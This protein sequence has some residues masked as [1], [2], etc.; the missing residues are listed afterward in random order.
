VLLRTVYHL[1]LPIVS[2]L[3]DLA[4]R[5]DQKKT[6]AEQNGTT[7]ESLFENRL[8]VCF[9]ILGYKVEDLGQGS[10]RNPDGIF[11]YRGNDSSYAAIYD[12]KLSTEFYRLRIGAER[13]FEDYINQ[14]IGQLQRRGF[15]NIYFA[16]IS[17]SFVDEAREEIRALKIRTPIREVRLIEANAVIELLEN[18]LRDPEF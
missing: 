12:A 13:Q 11:T 14:H 1:D 15:N 5:T 3:P 4:I 6:L 7:V 17:G 16:V 8:A 10:S 2:I 18:S 9:R